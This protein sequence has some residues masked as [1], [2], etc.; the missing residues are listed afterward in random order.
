METEAGT[1]TN[2]GLWALGSQ[3]KY[4]FPGQFLRARPSAGLGLNEDKEATVQREGHTMEQ[5]QQ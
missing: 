1:S 2:E 5:K 3:V 4:M